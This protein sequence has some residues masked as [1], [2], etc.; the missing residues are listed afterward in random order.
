[1]TKS[2]KTIAKLSE[3]LDGLDVYVYLKSEDQQWY[4]KDDTLMQYLDSNERNLPSQEDDYYGTNSIH[5]KE[6]C[7]HFWMSMTIKSDGEVHMCME[8]YNNEI[9]LG[10]SHSESLY[11]IWNGA[12]YDKFRR[13]HLN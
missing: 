2:N 9:F 3:A 5:W 12:L 6:F 11:E 8:D 13:D 10:D 7:K 4:R 1:M